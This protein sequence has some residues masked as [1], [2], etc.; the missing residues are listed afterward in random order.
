MLPVTS[1]VVLLCSNQAD[2][3]RL[4]A[5]EKQAVIKESLRI[6]TVVTARLPMVSPKEPLSYK[7]AWLIPAGVSSGYF[8]CSA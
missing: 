6:A 2:E 7:D 3:Y 8:Y 5:Y 1:M 4:F